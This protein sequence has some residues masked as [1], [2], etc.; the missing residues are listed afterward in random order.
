LSKAS[1]DGVR[2]EVVGRP[3]GM[4]GGK[5]TK[6]MVRRD[7]DTSPHSAV[8]EAWPERRVV[9]HAGWSESAS[10]SARPRGALFRKRHGAGASRCPLLKRS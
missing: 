3:T 8:W 1:D 2:L 5:T 4:R 9:D 7:G 10:F 6:V